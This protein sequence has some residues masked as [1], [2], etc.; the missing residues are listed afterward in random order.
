ML[1]TLA[2]AGPGVDTYDKSVKTGSAE[3]RYALYNGKTAKCAKMVKLVKMVK[4]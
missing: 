4:W 3:E 2:P 1:K